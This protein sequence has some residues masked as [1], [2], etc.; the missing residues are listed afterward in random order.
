MLLERMGPRAIVVETALVQ[1]PAEEVAEGVVEEPVE[2]AAAVAAEA[3]SEAGVMQY[4]A[5][6]SH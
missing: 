2:V 1:K 4:V 5:C 6:C 3:A